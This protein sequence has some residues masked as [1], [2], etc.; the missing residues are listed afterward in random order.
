MTD[1]AKEYK[2]LSIDDV[3]RMLN[4]AHL[5]IE[6]MIVRERL[7][8]NLDII[9]AQAP[10]M[11]LNMIR[12]PFC[13]D[14]NRLIRVLDG[15]LRIEINFTDYNLQAGDIMLVQAGTYFEIKEVTE[16]THIEAIAFVP[17][18]YPTNLSYHNKSV[19]KIHPAPSDWDMT[20]HLLY[21]IYSVA[22]DEPYRSDVAEPLVQ[23]LVNLVIGLSAEETSIATSNA[24]HLFHRFVE[25]IATNKQGKQP[26]GHYADLLC[27]T[28][29]YLSKI[30][31]AMSGNTVSEWINKAVVLDARILLRDTTKTISEIADT[32]N[33][34]N[35]SFF[36][37]FFK[38]E[39]GQTPTQYRREVG[40]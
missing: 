10:Q 21:T 11:I 28:P 27:I 30:V 13:I 32:L 15:R 12:V 35:D 25:L 29:Q 18:K 26:V 6:R 17:Q 34:P 38:R 36:C 3:K 7:V 20:S 19:I 33:F 14:D 5:Q 31:T 4:Q 8:M 16:E 39:T 1:K 24:E 23:A 22:K 9:R 37:R 2:L 40:R